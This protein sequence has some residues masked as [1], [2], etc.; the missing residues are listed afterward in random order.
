MHLVGPHTTIETVA[1]IMLEN[2]ISALPVINQSGEPVGLVRRSALLLAAAGNRGR[3]CRAADIMDG[4]PPLVHPGTAL[5]AAATL[6]NSGGWDHLLVV[7]DSGRLA[8]ILSKGDLLRALLLD[9]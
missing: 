9:G 5:Y 7:D 2:G 1:R 4:V 8:G 3:R 6:L